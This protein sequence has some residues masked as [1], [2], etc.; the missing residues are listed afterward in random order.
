MS[1]IIAHDPTLIGRSA[2]ML[3]MYRIQE[4]I[5]KMYRVNHKKQVKSGIPFTHSCLIMLNQWCGRF[6]LAKQN[7][8]QLN[9]AI[10]VASIP[11]PE[12][13]RAEVGQTCIHKK[14]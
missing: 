13:R 11:M 6:L 2:K 10:F 5:P 3:M 9:S 14:A 12:A 1:L 7:G 8:F 4:S